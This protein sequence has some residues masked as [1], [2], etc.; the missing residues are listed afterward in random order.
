M[1][2]LPYKEGDWFAVP[3]GNDRYGVGLIARVAPKGR[4]LL[5]YFF[6]RFFRGVPSLSDI[7]NLTPDKAVE[8]L[9][10]GDLSLFKSKWP[11]LGKLPDWDGSR[12]PTPHYIRRDLL[13]PRAWR[14]EY[15]D[16][17]P[18]KVVREERVPHDTTGIGSDSLYGAGAI[19]ITLRKLM[20]KN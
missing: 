15:S 8:V 11:I 17:D 9:R 10:F 7:A 13:V 18:S 19:E 6:D 2:K 5:G 14:V 20:E 3:L 16:R 1:K 12:W 4:I